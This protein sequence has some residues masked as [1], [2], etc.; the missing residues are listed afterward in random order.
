MLCAG[1]ATFW[2]YRRGVRGGER[3]C[4]T[5]L[6]C[7]TRVRAE[8]VGEKGCVRMPF[9]QPQLL[10]HPLR[11]PLCLDGGGGEDCTGR[12]SQ[13][14]CGSDGP[15]PPP[16]GMFHRRLRW[17]IICSLSFFR[18]SYGMPH[19][20]VC[21]HR[22]FLICF[23]CCAYF[24]VTTTLLSVVD[25]ALLSCATSVAV[26]HVV[27]GSKTGSCSPSIETVSKLK[28]QYGERIVVS[29]ENRL[30]TEGR[31]WS[32]FDIST[33]SSAH[34]DR[35]LS[36]R[37]QRQ[38]LSCSCLSESKHDFNE[39]TPRPAPLL[40]KRKIALSSLLAVLCVPLS[41]VVV[42]ACQL[43]SDA[44]NI[45]EY[46][47]LGFVT[48]VTGSKFYC[49]PPFAGAVLFPPAALAELAS[50]LEHLPVGFDDYFTRHE[51]T[52]HKLTVGKS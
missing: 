20:H 45:V 7:I 14:C 3:T 49:G 23:R 42:D 16:E 29:W 50:G 38:C 5:Y 27:T 8:Q 32:F 15:M 48:L 40:T 25:E 19:T 10:L 4:L 9:R 52:H 30:G 18:E 41:Q 24:T 26:V 33:S 28:R 11:L 46:A 31:V 1:A 47:G 2:I 51:V 13:V 22:T 34:D 6:T 44:Q 36:G 37:N 35:N 17:S 21:L 39:A 12:P 43:R